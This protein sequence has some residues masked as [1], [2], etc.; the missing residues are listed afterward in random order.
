MSDELVEIRRKKRIVEYLISGFQSAK[1]AIIFGNTI[2]SMVA[3]KIG[4][5]KYQQSI[6]SPNTQLAITK[7]WNDETVLKSVFLELKSQHISMF[8]TE[9]VRRA[10]KNHNEIYKVNIKLEQEI[11]REKPQCQFVSVEYIP[12]TSKINNIG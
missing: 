9:T 11:V 1:E 10:I 4:K 3:E 12:K 8:V 2:E 7:D 5:Q 6:A